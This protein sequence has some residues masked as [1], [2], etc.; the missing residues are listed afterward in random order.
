MGDGY[1]KVAC[2]LGLTTVEYNMFQVGNGC[3]GRTES[4]IRGQGFSFSFWIGGGMV[5]PLRGGGEL[6][7]GD[8]K[9]KGGE[10]RVNFATYR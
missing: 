8:P 10:W 7:G 1:H 2:R 9:P 6:K 3:R 5:P 4:A